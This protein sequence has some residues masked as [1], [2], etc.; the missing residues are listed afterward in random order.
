M[1]NESDNKSEERAD[2][3]TISPE[4]IKREEAE[5]EKD[6]GPLAWFARNSVAANVLMIILVIGGIANLRTIKQEVF[7]GFNLDFVM[8]QMVY[9]G[10]GPE[11]VE[12]GAILVVEEAVRGADG[13][14]RVS[15]TSREGFGVVSIELKLGEDVDKRL[16]EV[17]AAVDRVTSF[18][19]NMERPRIFSPSSQWEVISLIIHGGNSEKVIRSIAADTKEKL[20]RDNRVSKVDFGGA[21]EYEISIEISQE[22]LRRYQLTLT[23]VSSIVRDS[24]VELPGGSIKT[25]SGEVLI[26]TTERRLTGPEFEEIVLI[27]RPDGTTL[28]VGDIA[29]VKDAFQDVDELVRYNGELALM[30]R[31]FRVGEEKPML[32]CGGYG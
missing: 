8:V 7:P 15:S 27:A 19:E 28:T 11:E 1:S 14:K 29:T 32:G 22:N 31:V 16:S 23:Q 24:T 2:V 4:E 10:A 26:R 5:M 20:L 21:R 17:K 25:E 30:M 18:P 9:P 3:L 6:G 13:V 12:R